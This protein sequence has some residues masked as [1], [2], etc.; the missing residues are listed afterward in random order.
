M[1]THSSDIDPGFFVDFAH[2]G[3]FGTFAGLDKTGNGGIPVRRPLGFAAKKGMAAA[4]HQ[5][6]DGGV[7]ARIVDRPAL[8][9]GTQADV[10]ALIKLGGAAAVS[11]ETVAVMPGNHRLCVAQQSGLGIADLSGQ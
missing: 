3:L 10:P 4:L 5:Y 7:G 1:I 8:H 6:D 9:F 11:A 2:H